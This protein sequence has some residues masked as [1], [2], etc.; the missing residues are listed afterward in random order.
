M[1]TNDDDVNTSLAMA[2]VA[3]KEIEFRQQ[4]NL[5][6]KALDENYPNEYN[7]GYDIVNRGNARLIELNMKKT[8]D[9]SGLRINDADNCVFQRAA[10]DHAFC[11][12]HKENK[13]IV[14]CSNFNQV[15]QLVH[16]K[17]SCRTK[18]KLVHFP[19]EN[20]F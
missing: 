5:I 14:I 9:L 4:I 7:N 17:E 13:M 10:I 6:N 11:V 12:Q 18:L 1:S 3:K 15:M 20:T 19:E 16:Y 8:V 2:A